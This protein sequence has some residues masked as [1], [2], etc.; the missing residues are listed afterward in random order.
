MEGNLASRLERI[1]TELSAITAGLEQSIKDRDRDI[2]VSCTEA[3]RLLGRSTKT[4]SMML[5]DGR[6]HKTTI[7]RSTGIRLSDIWELKSQGCEGTEEV[8]V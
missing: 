5:C 2:L 8:V 4:I 6:L 1:T 3:A 7:G